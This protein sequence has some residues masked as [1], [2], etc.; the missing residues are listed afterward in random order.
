MMPTLHVGDHIYT[1]KVAYGWKI[2]G[3]DVAIGG[4]SLPARGDVIVFR[5]PVNPRE[6][7]IKRVIGLPGDEVRV[8][9]RELAIKRA[10]DAELEEI[11]REPLAQ[12]CEA[13]TGVIAKD[14]TVY[15]ETIDG[16]S[17]EVEYYGAS[18]SEGVAAART[19]VVPDGHLFV[20]GDN[21]NR[22]HDSLAWSVTVE[23]VAADKLLVLR[24]LREA[25]PHH[26][27]S[28]R[29]EDSVDDQHDIIEYVAQPAGRATR[30]GVEVWHDPPRGIAAEVDAAGEAL[31]L[32]PD[33]SL[34]EGGRTGMHD[35][36]HHVVFGVPE[37]KTFVHITCG[38]ASCDNADAAVSLARR[39]E[40]RARQRGLF[41]DPDAER[42]RPYLPLEY[43]KGR[44]ERIW[45]PT[46]RFLQ[47]IR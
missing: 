7:F 21:R 10:G 13:E 40:T 22:S 6:D 29:R 18:D 17:Y 24:D 42:L 14:C 2:H 44:A 15:T 28:V 35:G 12:P 33:D 45:L 34:R 32:A 11:A 5:Y 30:V 43:V 23:A 8:Q 4:T 36:A 16:R 25:T 19:F 27:F 38:E 37:S 20:L 47:P 46:G 31:G 9:G 1:S 39:A 3:T 41:I 26:M